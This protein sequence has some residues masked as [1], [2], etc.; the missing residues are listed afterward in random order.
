MTRALAFLQAT[1]HLTD[2]SAKQDQIDL[3]G[4]WSCYCVSL[5]VDEMTCS[6]VFLQATFHL[7]DWSA[8]QDQIDLEG[9]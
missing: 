4:K 2:W 8:K 1:F 3:E 6:L 5:P 7:T 9:K